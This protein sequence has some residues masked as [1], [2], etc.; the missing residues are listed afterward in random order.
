MK[1]IFIIHAVQETNST[2]KASLK[3]LFLINAKNLIKIPI[4]ICKNP[5]LKLKHKSFIGSF[6]VSTNKGF[7][8]KFKPKKVLEKTPIQSPKKLPN[9][10]PQKTVETPQ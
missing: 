1:D 8:K 6:N 5:K 4:K 2:K 10:K 3:L 7:I 9:I